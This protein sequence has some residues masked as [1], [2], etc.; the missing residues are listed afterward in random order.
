MLRPL[1]NILTLL[2]TGVHR[3]A[4]VRIDGEDGVY[5]DVSSQ[6]VFLNAAL[7]PGTA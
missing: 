5:Y 4:I 7:T 3:T 6:T 1:L 2:L